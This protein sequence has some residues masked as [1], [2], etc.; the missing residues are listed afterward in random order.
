[1]A[2]HKALGVQGERQPARAAAAA[3]EAWCPW[4]SYAV[5]RAWA[6]GAPAATPMLQTG[7]ELQKQ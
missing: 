1:V 7:S 6:S 4:R 3:S 5:L 2:L